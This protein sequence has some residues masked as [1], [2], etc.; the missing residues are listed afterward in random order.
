MM[1]EIAGADPD[2]II[3]PIKGG[4]TDRI[5]MA[6]D[7]G[8]T[9][10]PY[11]GTIIYFGPMLEGASYGSH[12]HSA[13][14]QPMLWVNQDAKRFIREDMFVKN[15]AFCGNMQFQQERTFS[16]M[17]EKD[18]ENF[19]ENGPFTQVG[20]YVEPG[21]PMVNLFKELESNMS[22]E[23]TR[24]YKADTIED[25]A[26]QMGVDPAALKET[27][28]NYNKACAGVDKEFNKNRNFDSC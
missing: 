9:W 23:N 20:V 6:L 8:G 22:K 10:A 27:I 13:A 5:N 19:A 17:T 4:R 18:F 3:S 7:V 16:I 2:N 12:L 25:L 14:I 11:P 15:F 21:T 28:D 24:I 26:K 1:K